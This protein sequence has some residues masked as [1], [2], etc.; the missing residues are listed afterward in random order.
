MPAIINSP[1]GK[2]MDECM[3]GQMDRVMNG[4]HDGWTDG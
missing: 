1:F 2:S 3:T 4:W